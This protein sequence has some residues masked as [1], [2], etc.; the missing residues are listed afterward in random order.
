MNSTQYPRVVEAKMSDPRHQQVF[1]SMPI[2]VRQ[3]V[4]NLAGGTKVCKCEFFHEFLGTVCEHDI[5]K[6]LGLTHKQQIEVLRHTNRHL[7]V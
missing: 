5:A 6:F 3:K 7:V 1:E 4:K 2:W